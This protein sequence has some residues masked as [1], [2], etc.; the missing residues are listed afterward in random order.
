MTETLDQLDQIG[1]LRILTPDHWEMIKPCFKSTQT[2]CSKAVVNPRRVRLD[3]SLLLLDGIIGR[4]VPS[5]TDQTPHLV[6]LQVPG[7]FID[8]HAYPLKKLDHD[9]V[10]ITQVTVAM[11]RH[12]DLSKLLDNNCALM[13]QLWS[14]TLVD[15]AIHR[16]W[17]LRNGTMRALQRVA[18]LLVELATRLEQAKPA[19]DGRFRLELTQPDIGSACGLSGVHV[20]RVLRDL[21]EAGCCTY[22]NGILTILDRKQLNRI[23]CFDPSYLYLPERSGPS[24]F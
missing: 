15:G 12:D 9:V 13:R 2:V 14:M 18:N 4:R 5:E 24:G 8:L 10:A 3:H 7:D 21:R 19:P 20:N 11:I 23:A 16:H 22:K 1:M 6:A 17:A